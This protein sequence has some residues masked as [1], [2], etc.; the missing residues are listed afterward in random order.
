M[1]PAVQLF[2]ATMWRPGIVP[3]TT[4][5]SSATVL[6][7][8]SSPV[9]Q[10][11]RRR[12]RI[13]SRWAVGEAIGNRRLEA[14]TLDGCFV[15]DTTRPPDPV[16]RLRPR[17]HEVPCGGARPSTSARSPPGDAA[18][19]LACPWAATASGEIRVFRPAGRVLA[20]RGRDVPMA[21]RSAHLCSHRG[22]EEQDPWQA[23]AC[24]DLEV[25]DDQLA[26][27]RCHSATVGESGGAGHRIEGRRGWRGF[28]KREVWSAAGSRLI[29]VDQG[30]DRT[31]EVFARVGGES[32]RDV[33]RIDVGALSDLFLE[34]ETRA[35]SSRRQSARAGG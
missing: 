11:D 33:Q 25:L 17:H 18:T 28:G 15:F 16:L 9:D 12:G 30:Q 32:R 5:S 6:P 10:M 34:D 31:G 35:A 27:L 3:P 20:R 23:Q 14:S 2:T 4:D 21:P 1:R 24:A 29:L 8:V 13:A 7:F 26:T 19:Q 22:Y